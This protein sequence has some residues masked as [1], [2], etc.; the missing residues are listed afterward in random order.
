MGEGQGEGDAKLFGGALKIKIQ[1]VTKGFSED[2][3]LRERYQ[4]VMSLKI[5]SITMQRKGGD[6]GRPTSNM[7]QFKIKPCELF[8]LK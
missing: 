7:L 3:A 5:G 8:N 4:K 1:E 2:S 6:A